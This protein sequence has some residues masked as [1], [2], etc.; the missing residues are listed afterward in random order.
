MN[1]TTAPDGV[2]RSGPGAHRRG[3]GEHADDESRY[4][5]DDGVL[6]VSPAPSYLHQRVVTRPQ[7]FWSRSAGPSSRSWL[8]LASTSI[9]SS[10]GCRTWR[11]CGRSPRRRCSSSGRPH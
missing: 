10:T 11:W 4:E 7:R 3:H 1:A 6:I 2:D 8:G 9:G 5:L